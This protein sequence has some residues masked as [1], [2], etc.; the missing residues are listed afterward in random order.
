MEITGDSDNEKDENDNGAGVGSGSKP[1]GGP[2]DS[3][4]E[5]AEGALN[6]YRTETESTHNISNP[7][8]TEIRGRTKERENKGPYI[9]QMEIRDQTDSPIRERVV[10]DEP[11]EVPKEV[12]VNI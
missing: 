3:L 7:Y 12:D 5:F 11:L 2:Y 10:R 9:E 1:T 8:R 6:S 4:N